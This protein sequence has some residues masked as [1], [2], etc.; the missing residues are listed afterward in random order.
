MATLREKIK[1][2]TERQGRDE[3][4]VL[5]QAVQLG[6]EQLYRIEMRSAYLRGQITRDQAVE[7]LGI[8]EVDDLDYAHEAAMAD[9]AWGLRRD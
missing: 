6:V 9:V 7:I 5:E 8:E 1:V 3:A 2:L 4:V